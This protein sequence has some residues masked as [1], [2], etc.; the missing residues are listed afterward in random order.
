MGDVVVRKVPDMDSIAFGSFKRAGDEV[1]V[2][3]FGMNVIDFPPNAGEGA[4]PHHDHLHDGQEEVFIAWSGSGI[5]TAGDE[6]IELDKD[7][8]VRIDPD[9]K[10]KVRSGPDGLRLIALGGVPGGVYERP[11]VSKVG[12]PD[13]TAQPAA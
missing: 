5:L 6:E 2:Q 1:G 8:V 12:S 9:V 3:A 13:P 4:Y 10:R 7:T 11:E